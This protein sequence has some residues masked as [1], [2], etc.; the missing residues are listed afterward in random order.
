[1]PR[2]ST[3]RQ[4]KLSVAIVGAGNLASALGAALPAAGCLITEAVVRNRAA[5]LARG[6]VL[7]KK[8]GAKLLQVGSPIEADVIWL[9]VR[10]DSVAAVAEAIATAG[11][12]RG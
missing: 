12:M 5:S 8:L 6:R 10:D 11:G 4:A 1:M 9:C 2:A 7:A 3:K